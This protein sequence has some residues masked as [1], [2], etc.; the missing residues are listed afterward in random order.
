MSLTCA[1][2]ASVTLP[3]QEDKS[4]AN[5]NLPH[6]PYSC[7]L[8]RRV[9]ECSIGECETI[10]YSSNT[11]RMIISSKHHATAD[12]SFFSFH[13]LH[14]LLQ[15]LLHHTTRQKVLSALSVH[16]IDISVIVMSIQRVQGLLQSHLRSVLRTYLLIKTA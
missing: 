3:R 1:A 12:F 8:L 15:H 6:S 5:N 2:N 4:I 9:F 13:R 10:I 16:S 11:I 7:H 14:V